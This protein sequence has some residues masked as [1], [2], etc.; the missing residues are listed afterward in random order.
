M[1]KKLVRKEDLVSKLEINPKDFS[2]TLYGREG[3]KLKKSDLS[4]GEK[5]IYA[6]CL[7]WGLAKTSGRELP[8]IIDTPLSRLDSDHRRAIVQKYY[9]IAGSQV[10][11]LSTDT[12]VDKEYYQ[13]LI[14]SVEKSFLLDYDPIQG[15]TKV[16]AGYFWKDK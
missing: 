13:M 15:R 10:I 4:A 6:I 1:I 12:E 11:I 8:I 9:P 14:P 7:L 3:A 5:E 16:L 2:V